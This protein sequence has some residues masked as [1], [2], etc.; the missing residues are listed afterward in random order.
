MGMPSIRISIFKKIFI[1]VL[2]LKHLKKNNN[3]LF[4]RENKAFQ[5]IQLYEIP[6]TY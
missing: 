6:D 1:L 5:T 4:S 3:T 2:Q